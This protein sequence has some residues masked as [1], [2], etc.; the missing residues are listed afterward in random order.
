MDMIGVSWSGDKVVGVS[1]LYPSSTSDS[2]SAT[3][4][5]LKI[6]HA[7]RLLSDLSRLARL[8]PSVQDVPNPFEREHFVFFV[9]YKKNWFL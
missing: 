4:I 5:S 9:F 3:L 2:C 8:D 7:G 1:V 6:F